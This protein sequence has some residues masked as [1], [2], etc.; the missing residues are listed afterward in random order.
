MYFHKTGS[1]I[2]DNQRRYDEFV[3]DRHSWFQPNKHRPTLMSVTKI[4][5]ADGRTW[6][7]EVNF[8]LRDGAKPTTEDSPFAGR[9][10]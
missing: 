8:Y 7:L 4:I 10:A 3:E 1:L 5:N 2:V 9:V 6:Y